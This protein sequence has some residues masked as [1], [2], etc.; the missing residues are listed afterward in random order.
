MNDNLKQQIEG[1]VN[2]KSQP[3]PA[4]INTA[5]TTSMT[6]KPIPV[7]V[8]LEFQFL[9]QKGMCWLLVEYDSYGRERNL[10]QNILVHGLPV[11]IPEL[12]TS[13]KDLFAEIDAAMDN[14][15]GTFYDN[16][17]ETELLIERVTS[18]VQDAEFEN[19]D[20]G[21]Q[22]V[23]GYEC[24]VQV[25]TVN[26]EGSPL[27]FDHSAPQVENLMDGVLREMN[28]VRWII[29]EYEKLPGNAGYLGA[30]L[31]KSYIT[32]TE[33]AISRTDTV[34]LLVCFDLLSQCEPEMTEEVTNG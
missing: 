26:P 34:D 18:P 13:H 32:R 25:N 23:Q 16:I 20:C 6:G 4:T 24:T 21:V 12:R 2:R 27:T 5:A 11:D 10:M 14:N 3:V 28:R 7:P 1:R 19:Q 17:E 30:Q 15:A 8:K 29:R 22:T 31:M 33:R 9:H